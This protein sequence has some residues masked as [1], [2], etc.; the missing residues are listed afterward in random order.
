[1]KF[2]D[3]GC[4][5]IASAFARRDL[6]S[7]LPRSVTARDPMYRRS[8]SS[9]DLKN[10]REYQ[11]FDDPRSIDWKLFGRTDRAFVKEFYEEADDEAA[12][13]VDVSASMACA[14]ADEYQAFIGS[15]AFIL[16]SLGI[17]VR[18][19]TFAGSLSDRCVAA[20]SKGGYSAV[21]ALLSSI[22]FEGASR[23][24]R[25][26]NQWRSRGRQRRVF[27]FS[28]FHESTPL[29]RAPAS[30][31]LFMIRY[32]TPFGAAA[33]RRGEFEVRDPETGSI[34][35]VPWTGADESRYRISEQDRDRRLASTPRSFYRRLDAGTPRPPVYW[36][37]LERLY[38]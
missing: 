4:S 20:G 10:I 23:T 3:P 24:A 25:S 26:F 32:G 34:I 11:G 19:W 12:F 7:R 13:L 5:T 14:P 29:L 1:M 22:A 37:I 30:G 15:A 9:Y 35:V 16:L 6:R 21:E 18:L 8:G 36:E 27:V 33:G 31:T 38:A 17:G 28:D 2:V